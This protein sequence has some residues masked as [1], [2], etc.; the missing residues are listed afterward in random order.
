MLTALKQSITDM[1][2]T[3]GWFQKF[4]KRNNLSLR[5]PNSSIMKPEEILHAAA[6]KLQAEIR[7]ILRSE[8]NDH[9]FIF[10][11][12][13][14]SICLEQSRGKTIAARGAKRTKIITQGMERTELL[15]CLEGQSQGK[16]CLP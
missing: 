11:I 2:F 15:C 10:N 3:Y 7:D 1:K 4:A 6:D 13:V 16:N 5:K 9:D 8:E 12:D 14:T